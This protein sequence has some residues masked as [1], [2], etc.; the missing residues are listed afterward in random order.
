MGFKLGGSASKQQFSQDQWQNKN[1]NSTQQTNQ[2]GE[3]AQT[4]QRTATFDNPYAGGILAALSGQTQQPYQ[5]S[6]AGQGA[7]NAFGGLTKAI[8]NVN[9]N[10]ESIISASNQEGDRALGNN[11]AKVRAGAYR[12]GTGANMYGQGRVVAD[13]ANERALGNANLRYGA[14]EADQNRG[15]TSKLAGASGLAGLEGTKQAGQGQQNALGT[16]LLALL[17]GEN[18]NQQGTSSLNSMTVAQL[19][20]ALRGGSSGITTGSKGEAGLSFGTG[21]G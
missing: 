18:T 15:L 16:Q 19:L 2:T 17:R 5:T 8:P 13:A 11:L 20:E 9:P 1:Q 6:S 21:G 10:V 14:F 12:G 3:Q 7:E 4:G